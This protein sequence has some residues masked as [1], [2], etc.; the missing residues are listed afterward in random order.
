MSSTAREQDRGRER[1]GSWQRGRGEDKA[2]AKENKE[3]HEES[4]E[5]M[6]EEREEEVVIERGGNLFLPLRAEG[7][8]EGKWRDS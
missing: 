1:D 7:E 3:V 6:E 2:H 5:E 4:K 8:E